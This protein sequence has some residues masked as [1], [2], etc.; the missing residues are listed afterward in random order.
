MK[1]FDYEIAE[2]LQVAKSLKRDNENAE[3]KAGGTDLIGKI[4]TEILPEQPS[5]VIDIK[6]LEEAKGIGV[7]D[8]VMSIGSMTRLVDIV[9][10]KEI[11][12][13]FPSLSEAAHSI[14][15]PVLRN[16]GTIGGNICQDVRC[17]FYRYPNEAAGRLDCARKCGQE[18]YAIHGENRYH[19]IFGGYRIAHNQCTLACPAGTNIS[20]YMECI[21]KDD[22]DKAAEVVFRV[23]PMPMITARICPHP[24]QDDCNQGKH[25]GC[26]NIHAV[27][28]AVG[29]YVLEHADKFY[30]KPQQETGRK[31]AVIG[32]GPAGLAAAFTLRKEGHEVTVI[33]K[34]EKPGGVLMYG[35]PHYRLPKT[36]V[37]AFTSA[38]EGMG[39]KF[40]MNTAVGKDITMEDVVGTYDYVF[41]GT[42]AWKQPILGIH[43]EEM[44][45][46]GLNFLVEVNTYLKTVASF[47]ENIIV[48]GGGNVAMDVALTAVRL[49]ARKVTLCCLE[50]EAEMPAAREE[51][52]RAKEE[53]VVI[54]NG[55]GL[56]SIVEDGGRISGL[57]TKK[58]L[59]V[60]DE[61]GK[62]A[63]VYDEDD[64]TVIDADTI[65]L[66]T[67]QKVDLD[68]L[69][70]KFAAE[71]TSDRGLLDVDKESFKTSSNKVYGAGDA[72]TGPNIAIQ[73]IAGGMTAARSICAALGTPAERKGDERK[74]I[75]FDKEGVEDREGRADKELPVEER[76]LDRED[77]QSFTLE[78]ARAEASRCM[79]CGCYAVSPSDMAPVLISLDADVVT[80]DRK[81]SAEEFMCTTPKMSEQLG[82]DE[83]V[84]RIEIPVKDGWKSKYMKFRLRD[85][86]DFAIVSVASSIKVTGGVIGDARFVYGGVS[87]MPRHDRDVEEFLKG[88]EITEGVAWAA[89]D[90]AVRDAETL[91]Y[92][93]YKVQILRSLVKDS[94]L[95]AK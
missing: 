47:G 40:R 33:D 77:S 16:T 62:F 4:K 26:V 23:N 64:K 39:I 31:V 94:I 38:L 92:N 80:T 81:L 76:A 46:F 50:Q 20:E 95:A 14:A 6:D 37:E 53:G 13:L 55:R 57:E 19:S 7:N 79:D 34:M 63:P 30:K 87:P 85:S 10:H 93:A 49:G 82:R 41:I 5:M 43:G 2:N 51:I 45:R 22:W 66:A 29:D 83:I 32:A 67:G 71:I 17:W 15:T 8:G 12:K 65:I 88:K 18:C 78:E 56:S 61:E 27:E 48:C 36:I 11:N 21:R 90:I 86:V 69:G 25:G 75:S 84:T 28:R 44:T 72:V 73:A 52:E 35:I 42:G 59:S 68:F 58:C 74:V 1:N 60:F 91:Q 9:E 24:C 89:A 3:F 54:I 70:D